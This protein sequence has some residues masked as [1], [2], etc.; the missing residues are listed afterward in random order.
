MRVRKEKIKFSDVTDLKYFDQLTPLLERLPDD[1]YQRVKAG[2]RG[3]AFR[4][5][6]HAGLALSVQSHR[7]LAARHSESQ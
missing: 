3:P 1:A 6:L 4:S 7:L 5:V 2:N